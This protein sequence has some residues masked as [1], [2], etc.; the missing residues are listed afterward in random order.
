M[1]GASHL[2]L[3]LLL[4]LIILLPFIPLCQKKKDPLAYVSQTPSLRGWRAEPKRAA[5]SCMHVGQ[6]PSAPLLLS[7]WRLFCVVHAL[8]TLMLSCQ[9]WTQTRFLSAYPPT[10]YPC[11]LPFFL[12]SSFLLT[13]FR[14]FFF[15]PQYLSI[16]LWLFWN[17][18][19]QTQKQ[20]YLSFSNT[21]CSKYSTKTCGVPVLSI[22]LIW[23]A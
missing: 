16:P 5:P 9:D 12:I 6:P 15:F 3:L 13:F 21:S 1:A 19:F 22:C 2:L 4:Y 20:N 11:N 7:W 10:L 18:L 14:H 23:I 8:M 17:S